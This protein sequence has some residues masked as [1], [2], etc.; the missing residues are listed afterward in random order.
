[1]ASLLNP[2]PAQRA[3][4][5]LAQGHLAAAARWTNERGLG[6]DDQPSYAREPEYLLLA[7]LLLDQDRPDQALGLLERLHAM[8]AAQGR[9]GSLIEI[10]AL[11]ALALAAGGDQPGAVAALAEV[12][13]LAQPEGYVRVFADE[14]PPMG[15]LLGRLVAAQRTGQAPADGIPLEYLGRLVRATDQHLA[16]TGPRTR[17]D[18]GAAGG[19]VE[20]LTARELEVLGL[21]AAGQENQQ[22]AKELVVAVS[23]VKK[24]VT[25]ILEKLGAANRT[26]ATARAREF[27]LLPSPTQQP[28]TGGSV[29]TTSR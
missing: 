19:L 6:A 25:H 16:T 22:I 4:L 17:P 2:V 20:A 1:V 10:Q 15:A 3:R 28:T 29:P 21:L 12:V 8:A 13:S 7:R 9:T 24:H 26:E 5:L 14:G 18:P 23:T 27:G 11:Q